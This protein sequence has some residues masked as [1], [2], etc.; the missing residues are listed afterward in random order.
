MAKDLG[1][2]KKE[3]MVDLG[4]TIIIE[5]PDEAE[6]KRATLRII[7]NAPGTKFH[8]KNIVVKVKLE[9][10]MSKVYEDIA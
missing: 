3:Q 10:P 4:K 9:T 8:D 5:R 6:I 1:V 7:I 2:G